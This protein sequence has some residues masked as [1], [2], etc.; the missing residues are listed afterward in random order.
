MPLKTTKPAA[1]AKESQADDSQKDQKDQANAAPADKSQVVLVG[2]NKD[3]D[4]TSPEGVQWIADENARIAQEEQKRKDDEELERKRLAQQ[5]IELENKRKED[6]A[7]EL[8]R[9][10]EEGKKKRDDQ[11][12][13]DEAARKEAEAAQDKDLGKNAPKA[14]RYAS[15]KSRLRDP[16]SGKSFLVGQ[17]TIVKKAD[18]TKWFAKQLEAGLLAPFDEAEDEE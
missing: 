11:A 10:Q 18:I 16:I 9:Q 7:T 1:A 8:R 6:E 3:L 13:L 2:P 14:G 15:V 17:S 12:A 4:P 5:E